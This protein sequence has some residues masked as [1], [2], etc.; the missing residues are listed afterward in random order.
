[1][2]QIRQGVFETN[3]SSVHTISISANGMEP[4]NIERTSDNY[5]L[6]PLGC[7][8]K[9]YH[10]YNDQT[11]KL[12]YLLTRMFFEHEYDVDYMKQSW[13]FECLEHDICEYAKANGIKVV[14]TDDVHLDHQQF[15]QEDFLGRL[16]G[17]SA[18]FVFNKYIS[19]VTDCD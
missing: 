12:S 18:A 16:D 8:G 11:T 1:M 10:E 7:F 9:D 13:D 2:Y 6:V 5:L 14:K 3:S 15:Y 4:C 17:G 19:L